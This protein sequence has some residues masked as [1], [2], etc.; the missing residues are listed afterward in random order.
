MEIVRRAWP[1]EELL[2][3]EELHS[4]LT[5][6]GHNLDS[7]AQGAESRLGFELGDRLGL[8]VVDRDDFVEAADL[9]DLADRL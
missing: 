6:T 7:A 8:R 9:E 5:Q 1:T 2:I 3:E 4:R